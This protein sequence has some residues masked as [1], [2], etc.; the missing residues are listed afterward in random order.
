[1]SKKLKDLVDMLA[2]L[3]TDFIKDWRLQGLGE[4][5]PLPPRDLSFV[6][7]VYFVS[8]LAH[9][10]SFHPKEIVA[11]PRSWPATMRGKWDDEPHRAESPEV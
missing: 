11:W 2:R 6:I 4:P 10:V 5:P 9:V 3:G 7:L 1:M 8:N